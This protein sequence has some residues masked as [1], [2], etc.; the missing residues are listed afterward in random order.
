MQKAQKEK[1]IKKLQTELSE[2]K[3]ADKERSVASY[4]LPNTVG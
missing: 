2:E 1:A 4:T 3:R